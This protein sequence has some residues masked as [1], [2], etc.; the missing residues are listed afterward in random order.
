MNVISDLIIKGILGGLGTALATSLTKIMSLLMSDRLV[1][2][3]IIG[4]AEAL[5]KRTKNTIDDHAVA[6]WKQQI[7]DAGIDIQ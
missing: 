3:V 1:A 5:V 2:Q 7:I 6:T 4:L